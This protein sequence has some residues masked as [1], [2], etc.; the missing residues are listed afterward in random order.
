M[1]C[2]IEHLPLV[3]ERIWTANKGRDKYCWYA[4]SRASKKREQE[5][6]LFHRRAYPD[7][8]EIDHINRDGLDNRRC[9]IR[10]GAGRVNATNRRKQKNNTSG[11]TG[12]R[13]EGGATAR[14][15]VQWID[16]ESGKRRTKSFS[17]AKYGEEDAKKV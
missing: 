10:E 1:K 4:K 14:W 2:D 16:K 8:K 11:H 13:F 9:N 3:Q 5:Y 12:V 17:V 6:C 7:I 15:K